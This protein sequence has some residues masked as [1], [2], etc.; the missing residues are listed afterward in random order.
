MDDTLRFYLYNIEWNE[1]SAS[2]ASIKELVNMG[3]PNDYISYNE[4]L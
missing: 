4:G 2:D 1:L 3:L